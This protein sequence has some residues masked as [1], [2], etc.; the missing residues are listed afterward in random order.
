MH[1]EN[2]ALGLQRCAQNTLAAC[3]GCPYEAIKNDEISGGTEACTS[4]LAGD[5]DELVHD[6]LVPRLMDREDLAAACAMGDAVWLE[7]LTA[8][9]ARIA[10]AL[11]A[12]VIA[13]IDPYVPATIHFAPGGLK[14]AEDN[15]RF[16]RCWT[17]RPDEGE[18][19]RTKW[20]DG[21]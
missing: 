17:A 14:L 19:T 13:D 5:A 10:P 16:W 2:V 9:G 7:R 1:R 12:A 18:R 20:R 21:R 4:A 15:G 11:V 8:Q 3:H 6:L